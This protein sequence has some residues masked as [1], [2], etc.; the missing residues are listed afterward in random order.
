MFYLWVN[1]LFRPLSSENESVLG[2]IETPDPGL[3]TPGCII[4][5]C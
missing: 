4:S 1:H 2:R 3:Q 5:Y